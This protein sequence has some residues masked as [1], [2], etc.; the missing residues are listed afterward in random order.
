MRAYE[1]QT[2]PVIEHYRELG[3]FVEVAADGPIAG[4]AAGIVVAVERLRTVA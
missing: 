3:R 1:A 2:A 4:I